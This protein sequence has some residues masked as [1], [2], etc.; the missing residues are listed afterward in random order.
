MGTAAITSRSR[1]PAV[2]R[3]ATGGAWRPVL[4]Q[5]GRVRLA[6]FVGALAL[7]FS[8]ELALKLAGVSLGDVS[9]S[10]GAAIVAVNMS[11]AMVG[12]VWRQPQLP[13]RRAAEIAASLAF[14]TAFAIA[15]YQARAIT[16]EAVLVV[17]QLVMLPSMFGVMLWRADS[18]GEGLGG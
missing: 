18:W 17:Q 10:A 16:A 9:I 4:R 15:L 11:L 2:A 3:G 14:A 1:R 13:L 7:G 6:M 8:S 5:F 12:W